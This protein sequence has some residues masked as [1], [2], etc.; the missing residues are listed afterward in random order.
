[1][2]FLAYLIVFFIIRAGFRSTGG[3]SMFA[4]GVLA[5]GLCGIYQSEWIYGFGLIGLSF[6][7]AGSSRRFSHI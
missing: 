2:T 3:G 1:M 4:S 7:I 6:L 5:L